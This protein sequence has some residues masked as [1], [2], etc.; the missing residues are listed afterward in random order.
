[1]TVKLAAAAA[2]WMAAAALAAGA[3]PAQ[4]SDWTVTLGGRAQAVVPYEG[5]GHEN[6]VPV[7]SI[8]VRRPGD[9]DRPTFPGDSLGVALLRF[10]PLRLGPAARLRGARNDTGDRAGLDKVHT[11]VEAGGFATLWA[12]RWLR[13][14]VDGGRGVTGHSGWVVDGAADLVARPGRWILTAGPRIGWGDDRYMDT[15]FGLT[16][17]EAAA[18]AKVAALGGTAYEP[19]AGRRYLGALGTAAYRITPRWQVTANVGYHRLSDLAAL[20]PVVRA[21]GAADE[22]SGGVGVR[23]SFGWSP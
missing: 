5:A 15:Y 19:G 14:H 10:G 9:P 4:A 12:T 20:S 16:A 22:Y 17:Q 21:V 3:A 7:P 18:N 11:A 23:Y 1:M 13:L 8:Q 2:V 6:L